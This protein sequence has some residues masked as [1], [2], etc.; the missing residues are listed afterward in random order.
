M[1]RNLFSSILVCAIF[2]ACNPDL[3][4][5]PV[6]CA[7]TYK[8]IDTV[9]GVPYLVGSDKKYYVIKDTTLWRITFKD[10]VILKWVLKDSSILKPPRKTLLSI[11][12]KGSVCQNVWP[13]LELWVNGSKVRNLTVDYASFNT[14]LLNLDFYDYEIKSLEITFINDKY[15]PE[16]DE[17][18]NVWVNGV[19]LNSTRQKIK[20]LT[21]GVYYGGEIILMAGNG[22]IVVQL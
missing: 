14:Y 5:E 11:E 7:L 19:Y 1:A 2:S 9:N 18:R 10:T 3:C 22:S 13:E 20:E 21:G 12:A 8:G 17:D 4:P 6:N 16:T 15:S